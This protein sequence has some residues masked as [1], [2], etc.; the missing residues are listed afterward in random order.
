VLLAQDIKNCGACGKVCLLANVLENACEAGECKIVGCKTGFFDCDGQAPNGCEVDSST[1]AANCGACG[2][3]CA[4][5]D[6]AAATCLLG[7]CEGFVCNEGFA[8]CDQDP[9]NGCEVNLLEDAGNCGACG[10][11]CDA[12]PNGQAA[13]KD[14]ICR[15]GSCNEGYDNCDGSTG[16]GCETDL[17]TDVNHCGACGQK[18]SAQTNSDAQ[19]VAGFC[20][21]GACNPGYADCDPDAIGCEVNL[22]NDASNCGV[23]GNACPPVLNGT[24]KCEL[25]V[26]GI[27]SCNA[28][29]KHCIG[30]EENGCETDILGDVNNCGDCNN[31]CPPVPNGTPKCAEGSC[32]VGTCKDNFFDCDGQLANGCETDITKSKEN[33]GFCGNGCP[34]PQ[35]AV[36]KCDGALCGVASC[37]PGYDNC[38]GNAANGC[39]LPVVADPGNCGACGVICGSGICDAGKCVCIPKVLVLVDDSPAGA[40]GLIQKIK[41]V[42][43]QVDI[44]SD[45]NGVPIPSWNYKGIP[46][47]SSYGA[48]LILSGGPTINPAQNASITD[49]P[50]EGQQAI[51]SFIQGS[52]GVIFTEWAAQHVASGRWQLLKDYVLL[53]RTISFSGLVSYNV[54]AAFASHPIWQGLAP[55]FKFSSTSNVGLVRLGNG[56]KKIASS[57]EALDAVA[58]RDE[59]KQGRIV[60]IA[61]A[62]NYNDNGWAN[63]NIRTLVANA[64]NW[65]ARCK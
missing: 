19:C 23:C 43:L 49:M 16:N 53:E 42:G 39:E 17:A 6:N 36:G 2:Q 65:A 58:I 26:C 11:V 56:N 15:I 46:S 29:K 48:M 55:S 37:L 64:A 3:A 22:S 18:C 61:H 8:D 63:E 1:D 34:D 47:P 20:G 57:P 62:G 51:A 31:I 45:G 40:A 44:A 14:G 13:C 21:T 38:D 7:K 33:C 25:F 30:G 4:Q 54:D 41:D 28:G 10:S 50:V 9:S 24:P 12:V 59:P 35:N 5:V 52:N 32:A 27:G 60:H